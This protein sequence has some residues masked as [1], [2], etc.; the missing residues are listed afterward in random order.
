[1][2]LTWHLLAVGVVIAAAV[3]AAR[4]WLVPDDRLRG[5]PG[6]TVGGPTGVGVATD[7]TVTTGAAA[8]AD[9]TAPGRRLVGPLAALAAITLAGAIIEGGPSDWSALR[10]ER[11]GTGAGTAALGFAAFT[12]GML[13]GRLVGDHLTDRYGGAA[14]LRG[15]MVLVAVGLTAGVLVDSPAVFAVGLVVAGLGASGLF[16]LVF[17]AAATTPGVAPGTGAATIS[18]AARLGFMA[19]PLLMGLLAQA[20]GLRWAFAFVAAVAVAVAVA[21]GRVLGGR[22]RLTGGDDAVAD[23]RT[24]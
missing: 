21:A 17:S 16:P 6:D 20:F 1:V 12:A 5:A 11:L 24:G 2:S 18:L 19:E 22:G 8:G 13:A 7:V 3:L 4:R 9:R 10:L 14:V 23:L 15:G